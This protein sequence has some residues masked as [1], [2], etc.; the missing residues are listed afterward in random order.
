MAHFHKY[1]MASTKKEFEAVDPV[2]FDAYDLFRAVDYAYLICTC[3]QVWK[4]V[5]GLKTDYSVE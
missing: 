5:V 4:T 2:E 3:G 1:Y